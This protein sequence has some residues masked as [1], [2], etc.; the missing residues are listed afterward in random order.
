M[1][2]DRYVKGVLTVIALALVAIAA[3]LWQGQ[4]RPAAVDAQT[5]RQVRGRRPEGVGQARG[6]LQQ[7]P[8]AREQRRHPPRSSTWKAG[9]RSIPRSRC[10]CAGS[11][12]PAARPSRWPRSRSCWGRR[13]P[14]RRSRTASRAYD[15]ADYA[16][17]YREWRPLAEGGNAAA[18]FLVGFMH[19]RGQGVPPD[20]AEA[21]AWYR[22][23]ALQGDVHAQFRLGFLYAYGR[24]VDRDDLQA[25]DWYG[26]AAAQ[27]QSRRP[28]R[29]RRAA[30]GGPAAH[31]GRLAR[32]AAAAERGRSRRRHRS[33]PARRALRHRR[34]RAPGRPAGGVLVPAGR[35]AGDRARAVP[36]RTALRQRRRRHPRLR[37]GG[38]VVPAGRRAG[39][40]VRAVQPGR[41]L[42]QRPGRGARPGAGLPVVQRRGPEPP[43]Q[44]GGH[45]AP[46]AGLGQDRSSPPSSSRAPRR[47]SRSWR[48]KP[49][50]TGA[51][52][53][54]ASKVM[55]WAPSQ[56]SRRPTSGSCARPSS[57]VRKWLPASGP[58]TLAKRARPYGNRI[59][60]SLTPAG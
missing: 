23:A 49:E 2:A 56:Q 50:A 58:C 43:R 3:H 28:G 44:G 20:P 7:Q 4:L 10:R 29:A 22:R 39:R 53:G 18:Q 47:W 8:P 60:V 41:A 16:T 40:G 54:Y 51:P 11:K 27:G 25:A 13:P 15:R 12:R 26:R 33:V 6:L 30:R 17:A 1:L 38:E 5:L 31:A 42:R 34:G 35:R 52:G 32:C 9:S 46:G 37:G 36:A 48:A 14:T 19:E 55:S 24:G 59:S 21:V 57:I 45:R